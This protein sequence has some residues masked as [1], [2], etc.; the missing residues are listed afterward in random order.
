LLVFKNTRLNGI[1]GPKTEEVIGM[2]RKITQR[3]AYSNITNIIQSRKMILVISG[4]VNKLW[5][6]KSDTTFETLE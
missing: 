6:T 3:G 4:R 1:F 2:H 5:E